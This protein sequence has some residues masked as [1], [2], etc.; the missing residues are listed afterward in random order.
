MPL[1]EIGRSGGG[2]ALIASAPGF[3]VP[4][5]AGGQIAQLSQPFG[6]GTLYETVGTVPGQLA[7]AGGAIVA[8]SAGA[9]GGQS[10]A[11]K[12]RAR[13]GDGAREVAETLRFAATGAAPAG[14]YLPAVSIAPQSVH[15]TAA[16]VAGWGGA[17]M[18]LAR[19]QDGATM[20]VAPGSDQFAS[21]SAVDSW[22][23]ASAVAVATWH[24]QS[25]NGN[26]ATQASAG[27]RPLFARANALRGRPAFTTGI[28]AAS[29]M[30]GSTFLN[31]AGVTNARQ[32][33]TVISVMAPIGGPEVATNGYWGLGTDGTAGANLTL[34]RDVSGNLARIY[35]L[36]NAAASAG[37]PTP[38]S[39]QPSVFTLRSGT[40][41]NALKL[42]VNGA[43]TSAATATA[44]ALTGGYIGKGTFASAS[45]GPA[46]H[47]F[48]AVYPGVLADPEVAQIE[49]YLAG[50]FDI[51]MAPTRALVFDGDSITNGITDSPVYGRNLPFQTLPL[52]D[53]RVYAPDF[54][55]FGQTSAQIHARRAATIGQ[56]YAGTRTR[57]VIAALMGSND[58]AGLASGA[59]VGGETA[60]WGNAI[61]PY[62]QAMKAAG[63]AL[64]L[65]TVIPRSW[66]GSAQDRSEREGVRQ[67][68]NALIRDNAGAQGYAVADYGGLAALSQGDALNSPHPATYG[69][70]LIHPSA[71]GYAPMAA[72]LA[73]AANPLLA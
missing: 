2:A 71:A 59:I 41:T 51:A 32:A 34:Y 64:V 31:R 46:H 61:L 12:V 67:A 38:S 68:L 65:G 16:V 40:G 5:A 48:E 39:G 22:A 63:F 54:A 55:I 73:Q 57:N 10:Y 25:G 43:E 53:T 33:V 50:L 7:L 45:R 3:A 72:L 15:A 20:A 21:L 66:A 23:G 26:D 35:P 37:M 62:A 14:S 17:L 60:I 58:I 4:I 30:T 27:N 24:D 11:L 47:L 70:D 69:V 52:L 9:A 44:L 28:V 36:A 56:G 42:R 18:Q 6:A 29:G 1:I 19:V 8:G 13:S 49:A